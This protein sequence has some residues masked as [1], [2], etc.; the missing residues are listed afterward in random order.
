MIAT[1]ARVYNELAY[2]IHGTHTS[3]TSFCSSCLRIK[4]QILFVCLVLC[5]FALRLLLVLEQ[6]CL[7]CHVCVVCVEQKQQ[8]AG[9]WFSRK[10]ILY[11]YTAGCVFVWLTAGEPRSCGKLRCRLLLLLAAAAWRQ[12]SCWPREVFF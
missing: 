10:F 4:Y 5:A 11:L 3:L 1:I 6:Q 9:L 12:R 7:Q 2:I 8:D